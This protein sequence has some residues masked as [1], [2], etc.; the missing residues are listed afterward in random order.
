MRG[1][2]GWLDGGAA[3]GEEI[4]ISGGIMNWRRRWGSPDKIVVITPSYMVL[5]DD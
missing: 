2:G 1:G 3:V 4:G 5:G